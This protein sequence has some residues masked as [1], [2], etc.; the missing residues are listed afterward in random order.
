MS[1]KEAIGILEDSPF[2][3]EIPVKERQR[4]VRELKTMYPYLFCLKQIGWKGGEL[5]V[6]SIN[7]FSGVKGVS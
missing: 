7:S 1:I 5:Y 2:Y 4:L 3:L 6:E